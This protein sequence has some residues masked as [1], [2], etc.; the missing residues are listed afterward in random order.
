MTPITDHDSPITT[1]RPHE[2]ALD[3]ALENIS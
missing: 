3:R 1:D 2:C